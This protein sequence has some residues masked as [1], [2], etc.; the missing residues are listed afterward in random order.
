MNIPRSIPTNK[1]KIGTCPHGLPQGACPI[2]SGMGG[3]GG[4]KKTDKI[5]GEMSWDECY[6]VWQQMLKA[7]ELAQQKKNEANPLQIHNPIN[8]SGKLEN[9][10]QKIADIIEQLSNF[11]Q[12]TQNK[13]NIPKIFSKPLIIIAKTAIPILNLIKNIPLLA[14]KAISFIQEKLADISDKLNAI[15]GE[16]RNSNEKK[17]SDKLKDFKKKFK[18]LFGIFDPEEIEEEKKMGE[19]KQILANVSETIHVPARETT[20]SQP[21]NN[22]RQSLFE[23]K[24]IFKLRKDKKEIKDGTSTESN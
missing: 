7:K 5:P 9:L 11:T 12:K 22:P 17:L 20:L 2:C 15:F 8:F 24:N 19:N 10:A 13:Y 4:S 1:A 18:S 23:F 6:A 21:D 14:Q 3:A 16:L